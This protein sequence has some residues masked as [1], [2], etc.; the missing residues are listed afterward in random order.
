MALASQSYETYEEA[1]NQAF[2]EP[3]VEE[4]EQEYEKKLE[5]RLLGVF[6]QQV[7]SGACEYYDYSEKTGTGLTQ[8]VFI[9]E[10][11][12][13]AEED[14]DIIPAGEPLRGQNCTLETKFI[15]T[16]EGKWYQVLEQDLF[17]Q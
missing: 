10:D 15:L 2:V 1:I 11:P 6:E 3:I 5:D 8:F 17:T 7:E 4:I 16:P 9:K 12:S 14:P 13:L